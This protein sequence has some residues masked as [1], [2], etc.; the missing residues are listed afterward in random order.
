MKTLKLIALA[1]L[2]FTF[3]RCK[4]PTQAIQTN[5]TSLLEVGQLLDTTE[6]TFLQFADQT[7]GNPWQ[8]ITLTANWL[9][10]QP[11]VQSIETLD[12][13]Y[14]RILLKS[15][16]STAVILN[17]VDNNGYS[18]F[19]GPK[20][21]KI[22]GGVPVI[23]G[24]HSTNTITNKEVLI[25]A[26]AYSQFYHPGEM[27]SIIKHFT[28]SKVSL[29]VTLLRDYECP[30]QLLESFKDYGLVIIDSHGMSDGFLS[31]QTLHIPSMR[32]S[33][34][35]LKAIVTKNAG[36]DTYDKLLAGDLF[37]EKSWDVYPLK[38]MWQ[39]D[40]KIRG[41][42]NVWVSTQYINKQPAMPNTVV[43]GNMCYS[44][45]RTP[46]APNGKTPMRDAF[47][48]R[49]LISYYGYAFS[50]GTSTT[51]GDPFC[52]QMEDAIVRR[53]VIDFDSTGRAHL[54][55]DGKQ[56]FERKRVGPLLLG[57]YNSN[58]YSYEE[59]SPLFTDARDGHLY[60]SVCI[61]KQVWM[62][63]NLNYATP[64]S[65]INTKDPNYAA[66]YG[67]LYH[68]SDI[69]QGASSTN[70]NPSGV[71]GICP[72]GWHV[73]SQS[74]FDQLINFLGGPGVA[75]GAMKSVSGWTLPNSNATNSSGFAALPGGDCITLTDGT[76]T[77]QMLGTAAWFWSATISQPPYTQVYQLTNQD[78]IVAQPGAKDNFS[79]SCRCLK[80]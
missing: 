33:A 34:D 3:S 61:G 28:D 2:A 44:A 70:A 57:Q 66:T 17:E 4:S 45:D 22:G 18:L 41:K 53:L 52:K 42:F 63:E 51:V 21:K 8:A 39:Q 73:P 59:C 68:W 60:K 43:F 80:D 77:F 19:R 15:G 29:K 31:G 11:N 38:P 71:Q 24:V 67:R 65:I 32:V 69:M 35:S 20:A 30:P 64:G 75:A 74:E 5:N 23:E 12:S 14:I 56:F 9:Q 27:E 54:D 1:A 50:D 49:N 46:V 6:T 58:N 36:T 76:N 7:N 10:T 79:M 55:T 25:Y 78:G 26:A 62:G 72:K 47:I 40:P 37:L 13:A 48:N 16:L